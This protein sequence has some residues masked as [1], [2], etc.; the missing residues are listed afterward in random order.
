M[1]ISLLFVP[2]IDQQFLGMNKDATIPKSICEEVIQ[3]LEPALPGTCDHD[4][5]DDHQKE[6]N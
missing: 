3:V 1:L 5:S 6:A 4:S 2:P